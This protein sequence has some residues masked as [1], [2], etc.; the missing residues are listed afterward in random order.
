MLGVNISGLNIDELRSRLHAMTDSE[1][2]QF[3][4]ASR[5]LC[6]PKNNHGRPPQG[7]FV[8]QLEEARAEWRRRHPKTSPETA[9]ACGP[10]N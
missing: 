9:N 3:G 1:L 7:V 2:L 5:W 10:Q 6:E 8:F 4:K